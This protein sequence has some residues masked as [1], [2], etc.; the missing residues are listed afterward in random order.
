MRFG[1]TPVGEH[2]P[3]TTQLEILPTP[4][5]PTVFSRSSTDVD[6]EDI[7]VVARALEVCRLAVIK[8]N[9]RRRNRVKLEILAAQMDIQ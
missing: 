1:M 2:S 4:R 6:E 8:T 9:I 3:L 5:N 7:G